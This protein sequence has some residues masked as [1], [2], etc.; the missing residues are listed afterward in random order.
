ML[1][2]WNLIL[3]MQDSL[4]IQHWALEEYPALLA[5]ILDRGH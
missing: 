3:G 1:P 2:V 5:D 4:Y